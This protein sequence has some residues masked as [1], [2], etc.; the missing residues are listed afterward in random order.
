[1]KGFAPKK[2]RIVHEGVKSYHEDNNDTMVIVVGSFEKCNG[3][4]KN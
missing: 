4:K 1:M 3:V 2:N